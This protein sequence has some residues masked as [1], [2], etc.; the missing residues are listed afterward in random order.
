[1]RPEYI[2]FPA[3]LGMI[4]MGGK[5]YVS[6]AH[7]EDKPYA[8]VRVSSGTGACCMHSVLSGTG[9]GWPKTQ[10]MPSSMQRACSI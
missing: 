6:L 8:G 2:R 10:N 3:R 7:V 1:M 4:V 9:D 5:R